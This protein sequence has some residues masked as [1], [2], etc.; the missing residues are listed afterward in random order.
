MVALVPAMVAVVS[1]YGLVVTPVQAARQ[2]G[3]LTSTLPP[4]ARVL[5]SNQLQTVARAS[6]GGLS[7]GLVAGLAGALWGAS[8]GMRWLLTALSLVYD[9]TET[10]TFLKLRI[11]AMLLTLGAVAAFVVSLGLLVALPAL[12]DA[13][14]MSRSGRIVLE[15][16]RFPGLGLLFISG[17]AVLYRVGPDRRQ[18]RWRWVS[19]GAMA[20]TVL[21]LIG[22]IGLSAYAAH[23]TKFGTAGA[24][25][26]LG[27]VIVLLLWLYLTAFVVLLGAELNA[28]AEHQTA[29]DTTVGADRPRGRR[30]ATMADQVAGWPVIRVRGRR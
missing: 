28:E 17:L 23:A 11:R 22:S 1:V 15:V 29:L 30:R 3:S 6:T 2:V 20:A 24:Y 14:G 27:A 18:P 7:L 13:I 25:G 21:W 9:E 8:S 16:L 12:F 4:E 19:P 5:V 26:A 10:R